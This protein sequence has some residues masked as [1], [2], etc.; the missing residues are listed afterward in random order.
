[1]QFT[2]WC[3][4]IELEDDYKYVVAK[5]RERVVE[6]GL[7]Y[8][9]FSFELEHSFLPSLES[10]KTSFGSYSSLCERLEIEPL[11]DKN[12]PHD[13]WDRLPTDL[14]IITDTRERKPL[15]F[16]GYGQD[17]LALDIGD[18]TLKGKYF[19]NTF[20]DRKSSGDFASTLSSHSGNLE[21]FERELQR[22]CD[23]GCYLFIVIESNFIKMVQE[24]KYTKIKV[25]TS[26]LAHT[27]K[28]LSHK[29]ARRCQFIFADDRTKAADLILRLLYFGPQVQRTDIQYFL[30]GK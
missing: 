6:K 10:I 18:Y 24:S 4:S 25:N 27:V 9:P 22:T 28:H 8:A 16:K 30:C 17:R 19:N 15:R 14:E 21:R 3:E 12:L 20:V 26:Y 23:S 13:F 2:K 11:F 1:L 7:S 29:Y 5:V